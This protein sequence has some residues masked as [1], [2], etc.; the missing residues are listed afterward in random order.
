MTDK[1]RLVHVIIP[2]GN[3]LA[4]VKENVKVGAKQEMGSTPEN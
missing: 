3:L 4:M 1:P 2:F